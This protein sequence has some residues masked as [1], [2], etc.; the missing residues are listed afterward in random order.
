MCYIREQPTERDTSRIELLMN[1]TA[2]LCMRSTCYRLD[3]GIVC[4]QC[5]L[6]AALGAARIYDMVEVHYPLPTAYPPGACDICSAP[7]MESQAAYHCEECIAAII[8]EMEY[9]RANQP[10]PP[11]AIVPTWY[12]E[13][14]I[15]SRQPGPRRT[16]RLHT[17]V[18]SI[19]N[20]H[21]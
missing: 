5:A 15:R 16:F 4:M 1:L 20:H 8:M 2:R 11:P 17:A 21:T 9:Q 14:Q 10:I 7:L 6:E 19:T 12:T 18:S 3:V 13:R